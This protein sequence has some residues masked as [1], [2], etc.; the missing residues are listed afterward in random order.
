MRSRGWRGSSRA[1]I[2]GDASCQQG[3]VKQAGRLAALMS[4]VNSRS[5]RYSKIFHTSHFRAVPALIFIFL[6]IT[7]GTETQSFEARWLSVNVSSLFIILDI[8]FYKTLM[9][10]PIP[11]LL[12]HFLILS[13]LFPLFWSL[14]ETSW[15]SIYQTCFASGCLHMFTIPSTWNIFLWVTVGLPLP[16]HAGP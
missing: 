4:L 14:L 8:K 13:P 12:D 3:L 9:V 16:P 5:M 10:W 6:L 1:M 7:D 2:H 15:C 11:A